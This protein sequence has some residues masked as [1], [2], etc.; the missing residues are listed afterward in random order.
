MFELTNREFD[1]IL[2]LNAEYRQSFFLNKTVENQEL[3]IIIQEEGPFLLE[4]KAED[5]AEIATI[6]PLW[7]HERLA[8]FYIEKAGIENAKV[9]KV[10]V[11]AFNKNW[12]PMLAENN[13]LLGFMPIEGSDFTVDDPK[14]FSEK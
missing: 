3:F 5:D 8:A 7:C 6:L 9:Q 4:D 1:A 11:S 10:T 2:Q 13:I 14:P 12:V